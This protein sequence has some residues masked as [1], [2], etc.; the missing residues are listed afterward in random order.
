MHNLACGSSGWCNPCLYLLCLMLASSK[1]MHVWSA[2]GNSVY[3]M[4]LKLKKYFGHVWYML[5]LKLCLIWSENDM[6][7]LRMRIHWPFILFWLTTKSLF[8]LLVLLLN[9]TEMRQLNDKEKPLLV[10]LSWVKDDREGR[11][12]LHNINDKAPVSGL[13][14]DTSHFLLVGLLLSCEDGS[15]NIIILST[16]IAKIH[17]TSGSFIGR[18]NTG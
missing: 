18:F 4:Q 13:D 3:D 2:F 10:Q 1:S 5:F 17:C 15:C 14:R 16:H 11:F 6:D 8:I 7:S 12:L 9:K